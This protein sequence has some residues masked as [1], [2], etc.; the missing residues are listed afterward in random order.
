M[1]YQTLEVELDHG[2]ISPVAAE[3]LPKKA[4]ALLTI[5]AAPAAEEPHERAGQSLADLLA[6]SCG[7][8]NGTHTDLSTNRAHMDDFGK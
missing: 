1:S 8:G 6:D 3:V 4:R 7:I 5:L 2:H